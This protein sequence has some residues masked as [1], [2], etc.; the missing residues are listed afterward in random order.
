MIA[1]IAPS[2]LKQ[3]DYCLKRWYD[4]GNIHNIDIYNASVPWV[5]K[6]LADI[7]NKGA[8]YSTVN[9]H[10]SALALLMGTRLGSD[11]RIRRFIKGVF[12]MRP[13]KPKYNF[14]WDPD[15]VLN[16][17]ASLYPNT[18][19]NLKQLTQK[20]V[21]LLALV[22]AH[23]VQTLTLIS[24]DNIKTY[25][26]KITIS[27]TKLIKTSGPERESPLL[28]LPFFRNK[29]EICPAQCLLDYLNKT[30]D[31]RHSVRD[32]FVTF[33][34][35]HKKATSQS[36]SRWIKVMLNEGGIDTSIFTSH[37]TRHAAVST[38]HKLGVNI[39]LIRK[40]AGWTNNSKVF[41]KFYNRPILND[42]CRFAR[43]VCNE[44]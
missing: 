28:V 39:D 8:N 22:T 3:Y 30:V 6:F 38:A 10:K 37:S 17:L 5:L 29:P 14:T 41:A 12:R 21:T 32:L 34:R 19:L 16:H 35:P 44:G 42:P 18:D 4:F 25:D 43:A 23:R 15:T 31:I 13:T 36:L 7:F 24:I 20:L 33:K 11:D 26:D 1:S 27:I 40:T 9:C 2:T